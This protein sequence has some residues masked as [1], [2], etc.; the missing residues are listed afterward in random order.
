MSAVYLG[1]T[2]GALLCGVCLNTYL[3]GL[4]TYQY[5]AYFNAKFD[6]PKWMKYVHF[7]TVDPLNDRDPSF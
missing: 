6:D 7:P 2:L 1:P 3:Y 5:G 4:V